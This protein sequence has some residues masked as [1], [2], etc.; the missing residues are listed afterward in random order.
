MLSLGYLLGGVHIFSKGIVHGQSLG[1]LL[2]G[3]EEKVES[4]EKDKMHLRWR[5]PG[6]TRNP[7]HFEG[8]V[9]RLWRGLLAV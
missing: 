3:Q 4:E 9:G 6:T 7:W 2:N 5:Q 8:E 1:P